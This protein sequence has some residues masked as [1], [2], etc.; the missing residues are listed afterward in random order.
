MARPNV[1]KQIELPSPDTHL[2]GVEC[3]L[4]LVASLDDP[5]A[6]GYVAADLVDV[7]GIHIERPNRTGLVTFENVR[8]NDG[9]GGISF[10]TGTV[11]ELETTFD[12][13]SSLVEYI[14]VPNVAGDVWVQDILAAYPTALPTPG[15]VDLNTSQTITGQKTFTTTP[16]V[17]D[18]SWSLSKI[19]DITT[20]RF[21]GRS[22]AGTGDVEQLTAAQSKALLAIT[23][24]D[25]SGLGSAATQPASAFD[26]AGTAAG[27]VA[28]KADDSAVVHDTGNETIAGTKT[29]S[30]PPALAGATTTAAIAGTAAASATALYSV[31]VAGDTFDRTQILA[32]GAILLGPGSSTPNHKLWLDP[33][34]GPA[35]QRTDGSGAS[36]LDLYTAS[37]T[38][39]ATFVVRRARG[40]VAVP[41][42]LTNLSALGGIGFY[43]WDGSG[44]WRNTGQIAAYATETWDSTHRGTKLLFANVITGGTSFSN[45]A[46]LVDNVFGVGGSGP[47]S[48]ASTHERFRVNTPVTLDVLATAQ[49]TPSA[50]SSKGIVLQGRLGQVEP[51]IEVQDSTGAVGFSVGPTGITIVPDSTFSIAKTTGLQAA[52]DAKALDAG[53]VHLTGGETIAGA[54][55]FSTTPVVPDGS[56]ALGKLASIAAGRILGNVS[57]STAAPAVLTP[58]QADEFLAHGAINAKNYGAIGTNGSADD[59]A[60]IQA[61]V[62]AA[63]PGQPVL[64]PQGIYRVT[65][66]INLK[67]GTTIIG[68]FAARFAHYQTS[69]GV[70]GGPMIGTVIR[71]SS[72][73]SGSAVF[74]ASASPAPSY[75]TGAVRLKGLVIDGRG[76][77][78]SNAHGVLFNGRLYDARLENVSIIDVGGD[79][80]R[81]EANGAG[82]R[83]LAA[84]LVQV[85]VRGAGG[86]SFDCDFADAYFGDCYS[87]SAS[88]SGFIIRRM[89][90]TTITG[91]RSEWSGDHGFYFT[92]EFGGGGTMT[93]C[94]TD[95]NDKNGVYIDADTG[96]GSL[97]ISG[98]AFRRDGR[99]NNLGGGGYAAIRLEGCTQPV[100]L[101]GFTVAPGVDDTG[102]GVNSPQYGIRASG[103]R[104]FVF[105]HGHVHSASTAVVDDGTNTVFMRG[106]GVTTNTGSLSST[107][108]Y[109]YTQ[110]VNV[111]SGSIIEL[112]GTSKLGFGKVPTVP[113]DATSTV[114][115]TPMARWVY[116]GAS[117]TTAAVVL[118]EGPNATPHAYG[119]RVAS[120]GF[121]RWRVAYDGKQFWGPGSGARDTTWG[122]IANAVVGTDT[123]DLSITLAGKGL[124]I[125]EGS[126]AKMGT[127]VLVAGTVTVSTTAVTATSRIFLSIQAGGGTIGTP[128]V[129]AKTGGTSFTITS[130]S[131][132]DTSTVAW[133]I[134]EPA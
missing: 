43:G 32:D 29:F 69:T 18:G 67:Q 21:L 95:R 26:A 17:P 20:A 37:D 10:P 131:A 104:T 101:D 88:T 22:T 61:A 65:S 48:G 73:F 33:V 64:L 109:D 68:S 85:M 30:S 96:G 91:S 39:F 23:S 38:T 75:T 4:R 123:S 1:L 24:G 56:W 105:A 89:A 54:K 9:T 7:G 134:V 66:T 118:V 94:V 46:Y 100:I 113:L 103:S 12:D 124:R 90:N 125:A 15:A 6:W 14:S 87:L 112:T 122:R 92:D 52:L 107:A 121:D 16:V 82:E 58:L 81:F 28:G 70:D 40:T 133:M 47:A 116:A 72:T 3:R 71:Q 31:R 59:T 55:T 5:N 86:A 50:S 19:Q 60:A 132:S 128:R 97:I 49:V 2:F 57:A 77:S 106:L 127:A 62:D 8:P 111:P 119:T 102:S 110:N 84:Q 93:G 108:N 114:T 99:N 63:A 76:N 34:A 36:S 41:T 98:M 42:A 126:N 83:A 13:G 74:S 53:V 79:G 51:L 45:R 25:V 130:T 117:A 44:T 80:V 120:D 78:T 115:N 129:S 11:Y 35:F 27:L